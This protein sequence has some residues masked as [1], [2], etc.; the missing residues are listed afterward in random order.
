MIIDSHVH[1]NDEELFPRIEEIIEK[2]KANGVKAFICVGYNKESSEMAL[3]IANMYD[4]VYA[5]IG[6]HPSETK[7]YKESDILWLEENLSHPKV[8]AIGEMGLDYYWD[9]SNEIKQ[10]ELFI[11]QIN[12][13]NKYKLPIIVH[14]RD[15]I[16]DTY[17][18]IREHKDK[19]LSGVMH[20]YSGS[21][22]YVKNFT[23]L[24]LYISLAGPVT[25]KNAKTPKEVAEK[26]SLDHLLVETDAPYLAPMPHRGKTNESK[27]LKYIIKEIALIK[28][29]SVE[30]IE[31]HT[32]NNTVKLF[33][34]S[35]DL[36]ENIWD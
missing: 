7:H 11:K 32:F 25:F 3:D 16:N 28:K 31:K 29:T 21:W 1:L 13:A 30:E 9:K 15:A 35:E 14:M 6:I 34:L 12:L 2:A 27:N 19:D 23:D 5:A 8:K 26:I 33:N 17:E 4:E 22:E 36:K 18:V 24:N 20:C 10:K